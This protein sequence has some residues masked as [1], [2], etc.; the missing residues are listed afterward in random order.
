MVLGEPAFL[1]K[2]V[3][4]L[5]MSKLF[6]RYS[7]RFYPWLAFC[8]ILSGGLILERI[9]ATLRRRQPW[10]MLVGAALLGVL[11]YHLAM[12]RP[13]FYTYG[14]HPFPAL[15][16][17]F[18]S[19]FHPYP[20]DKSFIGAKNSRRLS[21]WSQLRSP[22]PEFY[23]SLPLN[24]P[25]YYQVP[26]ILG[27]DPVVEG[28]PRMTEVYRRLQETPIEACK[29]YGVGWHLFSYAEPPV[30]SP[31]ER[32]YLMESAVPFEPAYRELLKAKLTTLADWHGTTL[33]E[34]PGVDPLAFATARPEQPLPLNLHC[35]GADIDVAGLPAGT[36]VTINFLWYRQMSL[37]LDGQALD[38]D[39]DDWQRITTTLPHKGT[40]LSLRYQPPWQK[41]CGIAAGICLAALVLGW[42]A[43]RV[44]E[45]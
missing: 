37:E 6:L 34:L 43:L 9:L 32:F 3:A 38:V 42:G 27:Y 8:A 5:P 36:R 31:N 22:A 7:F 11:A 30:V 28:Q 15:P 1:W 20:D 45:T 41:T 19:T 10:E 4:A 44:R 39:K 18:E 25:H 17:E 16:T 13:S 40:T 26:S 2:A 33:K 24:L 21:S 29:A 12:C 14:F 35:R 23:A